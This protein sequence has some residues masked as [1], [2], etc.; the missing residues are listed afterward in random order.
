MG[1]YFR[2]D[3]INMSFS[4]ID[5]ASPYR[6][7]L[8]GVV[9]MFITSLLPDPSTRMRVWE[10]TSLVPRPFHAYEGLGGD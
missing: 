1:N 3:N 8:S 4:R 6:T 5:V 9:S 10:E 7:H 2:H